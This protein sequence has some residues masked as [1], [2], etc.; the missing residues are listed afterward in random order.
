MDPVQKTAERRCEL[1]GLIVW[2]LIGHGLDLQLQWL[3]PRAARDTAEPIRR[4][5]SPARTQVD[6]TEDK[7]NSPNKKTLSYEST[8]Q[9]VRDPWVS[10]TRPPQRRCRCRSRRYPQGHSI[11]RA[12]RAD[13]RAADY[14]KE[15]I[16]G[17]A[18]SAVCSSAQ[19]RLTR[20]HCVAGQ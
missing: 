2:C 10:H 8:A 4:V 14:R 7:S 6:T 1:A 5:S 17:C 20:S 19:E 15:P 12:E 11:E 16:R 18:D 13:L 9:A 3:L